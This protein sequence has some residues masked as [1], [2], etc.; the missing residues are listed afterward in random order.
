[1]AVALAAAA[2]SIPDAIVS[3]FAAATCGRPLILLNGIDPADEVMTIV[4]RIEE[5]I[6]RDGGAGASPLQHGR[7]LVDCRYLVA[8]PWFDD[9]QWRAS[10]FVHTPPPASDAELTVTVAAAGAGLTVTV[11]HTPDAS[12]SADRIASRF[13]GELVATIETLEH[14]AEARRFWV[15][16][17]SGYRWPRLL[18]LRRDRTAAVQPPMTL[19]LDLDEAIVTS[20]AVSCDAPGS[21]VVMAAF[22]VA[23]AK[24]C[25]REDVALLLMAD[26]GRQPV[27]IRLRPAGA[28]TLEELV[29]HVDRKVA[30]A[31]LRE[32]RAAGAW[33]S[34]DAVDEGESLATSID[35]AVVDSGAAVDP[36]AM[37]SQ[38]LLALVCSGEGITVLRASRQL[39]PAFTAA[40]RALTRDV[41]AAVAASPHA[42]LADVVVAA[43]TASPA[44]AALAA[45][46]FQFDDSRTARGETDR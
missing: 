24:L 16:E 20:S 11:S 19:P 32:S 1:M 4:Q 13:A 28:L 39:A 43:R 2:R 37:C 8:P 3:G 42:R 26:P 5:A 36:F 34:A 33:R 30:S 31:K 6:G 23:L 44:I 7:V 14:D 40:V 21:S 41:V 17:L 46:S 38:L 18:D 15:R 29:S 22:A 45:G 10:G 27:P 25:G 12:T 9:E 35:V